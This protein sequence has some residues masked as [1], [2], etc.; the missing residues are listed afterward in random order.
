MKIDTKVVHAGDRKGDPNSPGAFV[1]VTVPIST[2]VSYLYES[3][4]KLDRVLGQEEEGFCYARYSNPTNAALEQVLATLENG[5]GA[6]ACASGMSAVH[7]A[8]LAALT[9][10]R[11]SIVAASAL[12]G[13]NTTLLY[14]VLEP[15]GIEIRSVDI[16]DLNQV[17][18]A[19]A[20]SKPGCVLMETISNPLLRVG[21]LDQ[22]AEASR[23]A[24]AALVVDNTFATPMLVRPLESE[25]TWWCTAS[26]SSWPGMATSWAA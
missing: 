23:A 19:I 10:R 8:I 24:G 6:L 5:A 26:P 22:I 3:T 4:A 13:A 21:A 14:K 1:P 7:I 9:D 2:A 20:E 25:R 16:C 17:R 15:L 12:Y 18:Q 11:R